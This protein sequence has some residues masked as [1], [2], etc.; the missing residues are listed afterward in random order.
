MVE[1]INKWVSDNT[2]GKIT[3]VVTKSS[4]N[5]DSSILLINATYFKGNWADQF[6]PSCT[7]PKD[8][9]ITPSNSREL[10][11]MTKKSDSFGYAESDELNCKCLQLNCSTGEFGFYVILPNELDG[12]PALE[13]RL[14]AENLDRLVE[15]CREQTTIV[16]LPKFKMEQNLAMKKPLGELGV[17]DV[18]VPGKADLSG[19]DNKGN[20]YVSEM[21][22]KVFFNIDESGAE[23]AAATTIMLKAAGSRQR[24]PAFDADHPFMFLLRKKST[25]IIAFI[26]RFQGET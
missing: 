13:A 3:N 19:I 18:F 20:L 25:G 1:E 22:H 16:Y 15:S 6:D 8:F 2:N 14:T 7:L 24:T 12:L 11:F 26:G 4:I 23:A 21:M 17:T 10:Q 9:F 5:A